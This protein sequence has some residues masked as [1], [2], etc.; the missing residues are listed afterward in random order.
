M[1]T[2]GSDVDYLHTVEVDR[3][4]AVEPLVVTDFGYVDPELTSSEREGLMN[5]V[6]KYRNCFAKNLS[7]YGCTSLMT[8]DIREVPNSRPVVCRPYKK[9]QTD[10]EEISR[11]VSNW[12]DHGVVIETVSPYAS[13]VLLVKQPG[14][15]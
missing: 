12:K 9:N 10:R 4:P 15:N 11:I 5:L 2:L 14:K 6:N 8:V 13:P 3:A 7:E 1:S